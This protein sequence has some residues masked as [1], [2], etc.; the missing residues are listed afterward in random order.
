MWHKQLG[1]TVKGNHRHLLKPSCPPLTNN[2]WTWAHHFFLIFTP[3]TVCPASLW[4]VDGTTQ[5]GSLRG[6]SALLLFTRVTPAPAETNLVSVGHITAGR[7]DRQEEE[8]HISPSGRW[9]LGELWFCAIQTESLHV[10]FWGL[11]HSL[12]WNKLRGSYRW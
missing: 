5:S 8:S 10:F 3:I 4:R 1:L 9:Y 11:L 12:G 7:G 6:V 2:S